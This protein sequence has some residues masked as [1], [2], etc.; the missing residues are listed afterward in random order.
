MSDLWGVALG[1]ALAIIGS[2]STQV[3]QGRRDRNR[4]IADARKEEYRE[5]LNSMAETITRIMQR[6]VLPNDM[7][8]IE[9]SMESYNET[10]KIILTR[11]FIA[12]E[13]EDAKVYDRWM[14]AMKDVVEANDIDKL[15]ETFEGLRTRIVELALKQ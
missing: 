8:I 14:D 2:V 9:A 15:S 12:K 6:N 3:I 13:I 10:L 1:G 4:W 11:I 5:L 7:K